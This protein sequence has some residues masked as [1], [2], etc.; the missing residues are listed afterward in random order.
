VL[1]HFSKFCK[2]KFFDEVEQKDLERF[3]E[4]IS[5][6]YNSDWTVHNY[7]INVLA[8]MRAAG[9]PGLMKNSEIPD[10]Q[11]DPT[12]V[13]AR[14]YESLYQGV[15]EAGGLPREPVD[16]SARVA[17]PVTY[18]CTP[19]YRLGMRKPRYAYCPLIC[20]CQTA[21]GGELR[22]TS[23]IAA[24]F[25]VVAAHSSYSTLPFLS[26]SALPPK[27]EYAGVVGWNESVAVPAVSSSCNNGTVL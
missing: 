4:V 5:L 15:L 23:K 27:K 17:G 26:T 7:M 18:H 3:R 13:K 10:P 1:G 2:K 22:V 14:R 8:F 11:T 12:K 16:Q 25:A 9:R 24:L 21:C 20:I 6:Q 19:G